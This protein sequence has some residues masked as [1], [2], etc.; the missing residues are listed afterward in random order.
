MVITPSGQRLA[1]L[2]QAWAA[3]G[4]LRHSFGESLYGSVREESRGIHEV[5][6]KS[7]GLSICPMSSWGKQVILTVALMLLFHLFLAF[8][9][10]VCQNVEPC[11]ALIGIF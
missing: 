8:W 2:L 7:K 1:H 10:D 9:A 4:S 11:N 5:H 6:T 3:Q